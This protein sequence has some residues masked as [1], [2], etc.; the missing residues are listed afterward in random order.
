MVVDTET[1]EITVPKSVGAQDVG[2][3]INPAAAEE[4]IEGGAAQG[5]G[6]ALSEE[7]NYREGWLMMRLSR[8]I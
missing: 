6:Y 8:S 2:Q 5:R 7:L 4:Q 3:A 1:G